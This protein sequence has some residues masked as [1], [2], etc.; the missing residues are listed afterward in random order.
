MS[1]ARGGRAWARN[2]SNKSQIYA[3]SQSQLACRLT[4]PL[5]PKMNRFLVELGHRCK[6]LDGRHMDKSVIVR[7]LV[8]LLMSNE[9]EVDWRSIRTEDDLLRHL[10]QGLS[11]KRKRS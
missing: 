11:K 5:T 9:K 8:R 2:M 10:V 6:E 7:S 4:I 3:Y 1:D